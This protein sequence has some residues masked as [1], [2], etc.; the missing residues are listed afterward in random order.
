MG[1]V[2]CAQARHYAFIQELTTAKWP[3]L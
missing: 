3:I 2:N 1:R